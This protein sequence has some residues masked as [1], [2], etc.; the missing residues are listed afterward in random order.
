MEKMSYRIKIT[1]RTSQSF[2]PRDFYPE[3]SNIRVPSKFCEN[4]RVIIT[5]RLLIVIVI[6][7]FYVSLINF[8]FWEK[9][10]A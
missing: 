9:F 1:P 4:V 3:K 6:A 10:I 8:F 2:V 7:L 5:P